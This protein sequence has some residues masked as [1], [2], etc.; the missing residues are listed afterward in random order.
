MHSLITTHQQAIKRILH[1]FKSAISHGISLQP[2]TNLSLTC[3]TDVDQVGYLDDWKSTSGHCCF[4]SPNL[5]SWSYTKQKVVSHSSDE[6]EYKGLTNAA[7]G[8]Y[9][10][11]NISH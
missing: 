9:L 8:T 6:S 1:Y 5:I 7:L 2:S 3:Y 10:D 4:L 11:R